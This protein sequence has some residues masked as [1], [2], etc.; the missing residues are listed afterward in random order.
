VH[1][2]LFDLVRDDDGKYK[3]D[4]VDQTALAPYYKA[5]EALEA[6]KANLEAGDVDAG[7]VLFTDDLWTPQP[8]SQAPN[9]AVPS[10]VVIGT[11]IARIVVTCSVTVSRWDE[12]AAAGRATGEGLIFPHIMIASTTEL[13]LRAFQARSGGAGPVR[14]PL[15]DPGGRASR[16]SYRTMKE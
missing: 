15:E 16:T 7:E 6:A 3:A 2:F 11:V 14:R 4:P 5:L 8:S 12:Q 9:G 13:D 1:V 10:V